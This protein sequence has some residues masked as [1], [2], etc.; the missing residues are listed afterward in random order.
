LPQGAGEFF[1]MTQVGTV[2]VIIPFFQR[3]PGLLER[4]VGSVLSQQGS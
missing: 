2:S 4:A 1:A 3:E